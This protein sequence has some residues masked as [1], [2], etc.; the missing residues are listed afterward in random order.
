MI[1]HSLLSRI[2]FNSSH[3][4]FSIKLGVVYAVFNYYGTKLRGRPL[5]PFLTWESIPDG[6]VICALLIGVSALLFLFVAYIAN[7]NKS[8]V[9]IPK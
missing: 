4:T 5:Y 9:I 8:A 2:P 1:L 7:M 3:Y 6:I